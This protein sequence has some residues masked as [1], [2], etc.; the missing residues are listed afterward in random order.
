MEE[1]FIFDE[2]LN[3]INVMNNILI[4]IKDGTKD[5]EKI[6]ELFRAMHT[7]KGTADLIFMS[8]IVDIIHKSEDLL[9]AIRDGKIEFD[10]VFAKLFIEIKDYIKLIVVNT[11]E[12]FTD[13]E[14][15]EALKLYFDKKFEAFQVKS[16]LLITDDENASKIKADEL[17]G[18]T[19]VKAHDFIGAH[20]ALKFCKISMLFLDV[21]QREELSLKFIDTLK[22]KPEYRYLP[23]VLIVPEHYK[24]LKSIGQQACARAWLTRPLNKVK[25]FMIIKKILG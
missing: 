22:N 8:D 9:Q 20:K 2:I 19:V 5:I 17:M 6:N 13:D 7:I 16:I 10:S 12:G 1:N 11:N 14:T 3:K 25:F 4:D 21:Y 24:N 15:V 23:V 18:Y